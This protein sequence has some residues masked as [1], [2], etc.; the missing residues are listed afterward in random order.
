MTVD[1]A[2]R[3]QW[4]DHSISAAPDQAAASIPALRESLDHDDT[5]RNIATV[6]L[7]VFHREANR[8]P[9]PGGQEVAEGWETGATRI[10]TVTKGRR[11]ARAP[12]V[13]PIAIPRPT[14]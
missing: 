2:A 7:V 4:V 12:R 5:A 11:R 14:A 3:D 6:G 1:A 10:R 8:S 13:H 9:P